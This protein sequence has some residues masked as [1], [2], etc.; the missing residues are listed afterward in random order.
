MIF[1]TLLCLAVSA[2]AGSFTVTGDPPGRC[3]MRLTVELTPDVPNMIDAGFLSS[4]LSDNPNYQL[5]LLRQ[6]SGSVVVLE[7]IGPG[8]YY[9]CQ[10]VIDTIR[11][12]SRVQS[13]QVD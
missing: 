5:S 8:P 3:D 7:F 11:R 13:V 1:G 12:D 2:T 6:E 9:I 4:L 10:H